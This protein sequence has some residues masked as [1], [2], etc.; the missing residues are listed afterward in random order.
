M[1]KLSDWPQAKELASLHGFH[2][3]EQRPCQ[4]RLLLHLRPEHAAAV[5]LH[6]LKHVADSEPQLPE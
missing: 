3:L 1:N 5:V 4:K 2:L 6:C